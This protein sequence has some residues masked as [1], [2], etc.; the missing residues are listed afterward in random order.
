MKILTREQFLSLRGPV[1]YSKV[2]AGNAEP[3]STLFIK[4][5]T[6]GNDWFCKAFDGKDVKLDSELTGKVDMDA[7]SYDEQYEDDRVRFAIFDTYDINEFM[8]KLNDC[9]YN[10]ITNVRGITPKFNGE[11]TPLLAKM[12]YAD[13]TKR[14]IWVVLEQHPYVGKI[15]VPDV[16]IDDVFEVVMKHTNHYIHEPRVDK[17]GKEILI[18]YPNCS[19]PIDSIINILKTMG[20]RIDGE[21][22]T[23]WTF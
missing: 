15:T 10:D 14:R 4:Y 2:L 8:V 12:H 17:F 16:D 21:S 9:I 18:P 23:F 6:D 5:D 19:N 7:N 22:N 1:L 11:G 3:E 13:K 20:G